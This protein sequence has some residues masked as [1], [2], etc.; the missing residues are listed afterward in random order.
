VA[1][2]TMQPEAIAAGALTHINI[3]FM[4]FDDTFNLI[5]TQGDLV[6]RVSRLKMTYPGLRDDIAIGGWS[7]NDP[8]T[9]YFRNPS[10]I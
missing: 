1:C 10:A 4:L 3:A 6:A 5:D 9:Q 2:D 8:P 7:F